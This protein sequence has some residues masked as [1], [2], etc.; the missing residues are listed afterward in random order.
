MMLRYRFLWFVIIFTPLAYANS[1][2][3]LTADFS[4]AMQAYGDQV[5]YCSSFAKS[6]HKAFPATDWFLSLNNDD[7]KR[8][9][10]YL[11][12]DNSDKCSVKQRLALVNVLDRFPQVTITTDKHPDG[13]ALDEIRQGLGLVEQIDHQEKIAGLD[14]SEI[15]KIQAQ[16]DQP[17]NPISVME[18]LA[19]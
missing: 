17:F 5:G 10:L 1:D 8:V 19:L 3:S 2:E 11:Y 13:V 6:N 7:K 9:L 12:L 4:Q 16:F 14:F 18:A 15:E